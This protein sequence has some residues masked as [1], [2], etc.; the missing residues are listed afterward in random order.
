MHVGVNDPFSARCGQ[1]P[2]AIR[3]R[4]SLAPPQEKKEMQL[5]WN[6][7]IRLE[8]VVS[9]MAKNMHFMFCY[10]VGSS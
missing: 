4:T 3:P 2:Q 1:C 7:P 9:R 6:H 8:F 10:S 5:K